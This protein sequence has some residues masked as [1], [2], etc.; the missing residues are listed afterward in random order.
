MRIYLSIFLIP[1][2]FSCATDKKP[3]MQ[4]NSLK[5]SLSEKAKRLS[6]KYDLT[7]SWFDFECI[8][9]KVT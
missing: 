7:Q 8:Y 9:S 5:D 6:S 2:L 4:Q 3:D 1:L